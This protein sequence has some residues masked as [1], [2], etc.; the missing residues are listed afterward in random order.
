MGSSPP[1]VLQGH[2]KVKGLP[3]D[4]SAE[5]FPVRV[6]LTQLPPHVDKAMA[7]SPSHVCCPEAGFPGVNACSCWAQGPGPETTP[8][9]VPTPRLCLTPVAPKLHTLIHADT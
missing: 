1:R 7:K 6:D 5:W 9:P 3:T 8:T 2:C 4:E